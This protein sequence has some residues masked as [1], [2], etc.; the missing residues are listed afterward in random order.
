MWCYAVFVSVSLYETTIVFSHEIGSCAFALGS[1]D[2][3]IYFQ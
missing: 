3:K 1:L 2:R